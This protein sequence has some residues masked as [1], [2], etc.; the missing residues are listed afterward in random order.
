M[1][2][3]E[4]RPRVGNRWLAVA[5]QTNVHV[6]SCARR[7]VLRVRMRASQL[8]GPQLSHMHKPVGGTGGTSCWGIARSLVRIA[9]LLQVVCDF[10]KILECAK[11]SS[12]DVADVFKLCF[13]G[14]VVARVGGDPPPSVCL[15]CSTASI[16]GEKVDFYICCPSDPEYR[17]P[18]WLA[19]AIRHRGMGVTQPGRLLC[20]CAGQSGRGWCVCSTG[21]GKVTAPCGSRFGCAFAHSML[22]F[23]NLVTPFVCRPRL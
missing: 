20:D 1:S 2:K 6:L 4:T 12:R 13:V 7:G 5:S 3:R 10:N 23:G 21:V 8:S 19:S 16:F 22:R 11:D 9:R 15:P 17:A 18:A 14:E